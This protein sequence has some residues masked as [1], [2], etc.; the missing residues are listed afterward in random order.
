MEFKT[1]IPLTMPLQDVVSTIRLYD[2]FIEDCK[3]RNH[4]R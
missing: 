2:K 3:K 1:N 4:R